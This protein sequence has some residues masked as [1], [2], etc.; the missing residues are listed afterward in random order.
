MSEY[1]SVRPSDLFLDAINPRLTE[2]NEGQ[3]EALR[4]IARQ[5]NRKLL[6]LAR[7]IIQNGLDPSS[8]MI[9]VP[10]EDTDRRYVVIEGN[11][12]LAALKVL[13]NSELVAGAVED[14]VLSAFRE[15]SRAY[16]DNP[17]QSIEC[18]RF[19]TRDEA[20]HWIELRH[21]GERD[22]VGVVKWGTHEQDRFKS[23]S[24][25]RPLHMQVLD[26]LERA[27]RLDA[28]GRQRVP[29]TTLM[30][31]LSS[32]D[33]R[34]KLGIDLQNGELKIF[35]SEKKVA[36]ALMYVVDD[37]ASG[38]FVELSID[39]YMQREKLQWT[40]ADSLR[41]KMD[42]VLGHL[43]KASKLTEHQAAPVRKAMQKGSLLAPSI[44]LMHGYVHNVG[45]VPTSRDLRAMW[46]GMQP[47]IVAQ[48][49][50]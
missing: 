49:S 27:G 34:A 10:H 16:Q 44:M 23:R 46:I 38:V 25:S 37:L 3:R 31:I 41:A 11:R 12:R 9:V 29:A 6:A 7:D 35:G 20:N 15:L 36:A 40:D 4:A 33:V 22:G 1:I 28:A 45:F 18:V 5:Q 47:F 2:P 24:G 8:L 43:L 19:K 50:P 14:S 21:T 26:F 39:A 13:E 17:I 30:R 32:P 42:R 48:W